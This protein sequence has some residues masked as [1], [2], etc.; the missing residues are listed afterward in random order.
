MGSTV[1]VLGG[2]VATGK[3]TLARR[4]GRELSA[5][6]LSSDLIGQTIETSLGRG[7]AV[8]SNAYWA[9]Y[10]VVFRLCEEFISCG[11]TVIL[12]INMGWQF[13]WDYLDALQERHPDTL[14]VPIVL[15]CPWDT[16]VERARMRYTRDPSRAQ[17]P[18]AYMEHEQTVEVWA[19]LERLHRPDVVFIDASRC[20]DEVYNDLV[21]ALAAAHVFRTGASRTKVP[22]LKDLLSRDRRPCDQ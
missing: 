20:E 1:I 18:E 10:D 6:R 4:L 5:P 14:V 8:G 16:C 17:P 22:G 15:R 3:T 19:F 11:L 2:F 21:E 9:A 12:D 7:E 13:Q